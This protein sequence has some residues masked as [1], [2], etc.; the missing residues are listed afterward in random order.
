[1]KTMQKT[2]LITALLAAP[3]AAAQAQGDA[4]RHRAWIEAQ[5]I[6]VQPTLTVKETEIPADSS[7]GQSQPMS[8]S[9]NTPA[10]QAPSTNMPATPSSS[11]SGSY[12]PS[13]NG[14]Q[15]MPGHQ[16]MESGSGMRMK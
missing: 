8:P 13:M 5:K 14:Q 3:L 6:D 11:G 9:Y 15:P 7:T 16:G 1:M 2:L 12:A 4:A 10:G